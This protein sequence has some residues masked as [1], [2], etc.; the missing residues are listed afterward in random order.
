MSGVLVRSG[1]DWEW[2]LKRWSS[3]CPHVID[4][5]HHVRM[6]LLQANIKSRQAGQLIVQSRS[7][8]KLKKQKKKT[9]AL[10]IRAGEGSPPPPPPL[11]GFITGKLRTGS[12]EN[13]KF[14]D[15]CY[16]GWR[17]GSSA[18]RRLGPSS[19]FDRQNGGYAY[20]GNQLQRVTWSSLTPWRRQLEA[21]GLRS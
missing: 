15:L 6:T 5:G 19:G 12:T 9:L 10:L 8:G 13:A 18:T 1:T 20:V 17:F 16:V 11:R 7:E 3:V 2:W 21:E 4:A 14:L